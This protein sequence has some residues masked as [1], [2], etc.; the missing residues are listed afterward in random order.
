MFLKLPIL[1]NQNY[2]YNLF[3]LTKYLYI[4]KF[5]LIIPNKQIKPIK[6]DTAKSVLNDI[7]LFN[8]KT[9]EKDVK[10]LS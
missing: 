9:F 4:L 2:L 7:H 1:S 10:Y 6:K 5:I 8:A 3:F